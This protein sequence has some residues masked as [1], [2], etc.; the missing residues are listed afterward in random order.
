[1]KSIKFIPI[2]L[3]VFQLTIFDMTEEKKITKSYIDLSQFI[4]SSDAAKMKL[5]WNQP[6]QCWIR[7]FVSI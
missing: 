3:L 2:Y 6:E 4:Y 7:A 5:N 1:M